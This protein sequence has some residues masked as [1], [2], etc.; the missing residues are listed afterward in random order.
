MRL[1]NFFIFI[2]IFALPPNCYAEDADFDFILYCYN[3]KGSWE[4]NYLLIYSDWTAEYLRTDNAYDY[5]D[6]FVLGRAAGKI[7]LE[8]ANQILA[9]LQN[10]KFD[11]NQK[12]NPLAIRPISLLAIKNLAGQII[13]QPHPD[14]EHQELL[15]A[16]DELEELFLQSIEIIKNH[17]NTTIISFEAEATL[18][19]NRFVTFLLKITN[20]GNTA[21]NIENIFNLPFFAFLCY[22][23][24]GSDIRYNNENTILLNS[25]FDIKQEI[26]KFSPN[27]PLQMEIKSKEP[28]NLER[29]AFT[30][31]LQIK[32]VTDSGDKITT[33]TT[34]AVV[35]YFDP[36]SDVVPEKKII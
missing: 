26:L 21:I 4:Y 10:F 5:D 7:P 24:N 9:I 18:D 29:L 13:E 32:E 23:K 11:P 16:Y 25:N 30:I 17:G 8:I 6:F 3:A 31:T 35:V 34:R 1:I 36:S 15:Q 20:T 22:D 2:L 28:V 19:D 14:E 33:F 12:M 27:K